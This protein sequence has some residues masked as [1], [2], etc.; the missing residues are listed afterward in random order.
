MRAVSPRGQ[1]GTRACVD[2]RD[3]SVTQTSNGLDQAAAVV[4]EFQLLAQA[5]NLDVDAAIRLGC[6]NASTRDPTRFKCRSLISGV[7]TCQV[8]SSFAR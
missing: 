1:S 2:V 3:E 5:A 8:G 7:I 6:G 4:L